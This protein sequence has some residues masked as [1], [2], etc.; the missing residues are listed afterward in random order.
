MVQV[1]YGAR[2]VR[3]LFAFVLELPRRG[4]EIKSITAIT[5]KADGIRLLRKM[6]IPPVA[7]S[8]H[9]QASLFDS[10]Y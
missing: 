4:V 10:C 2:L 1:G 6:G 8:C 7:L 5:Y 9:R 3:G